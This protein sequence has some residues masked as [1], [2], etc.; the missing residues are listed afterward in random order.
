MKERLTRLIQGC[1]SNNRKAQKELYE[2]YKDQFYG[3]V[4]RYI[5][6]KY[7]AEDV[8]VQAMYRIFSKINTFGDKGSFEGWMKKILINECL[9]HI[10]KP[11][12]KIYNT[13]MKDD[14]AVHPDSVV[15]RL[16]HED[17][18]ALI[19]RLPLG[20]RTV[21]NLYII[22]GYKHK[23]IAQLLDISINTSKSQLLLAKKRMKTLINAHY[24]ER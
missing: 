15:D 23:E 4:R 21:F 14:L 11:S 13:E 5:K 10:R 16:Q 20:Y 24:N 17:L 1:K 6:D 22:E 2:L 12:N 9:M 8:F 18:L 19:Q 7:Q 3:I